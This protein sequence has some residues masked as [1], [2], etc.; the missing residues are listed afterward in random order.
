M[1]RRHPHNQVAMYDAVRVHSEVDFRGSCWR[2]TATSWE[3][4]QGKVSME[5]WC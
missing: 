1:V 2:Q 4:D 3:L 5:R